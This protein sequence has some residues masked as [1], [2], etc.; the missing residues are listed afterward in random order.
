MIM[1]M[2][3]VVVLVMVGVM[4]IY[5]YEYWWWL[6]NDVFADDAG[7]MMAAGWSSL[8]SK[9]EQ[10]LMFD[11]MCR[12]GPVVPWVDDMNAWFIGA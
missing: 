6:Y 8:F 2:V 3:V 9:A 4:L 7:A 5:V 1:I 11:L 12:L 10:P